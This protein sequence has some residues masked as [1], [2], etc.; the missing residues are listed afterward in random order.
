MIDRIECIFFGIVSSTSTP[1]DDGQTDEISNFSQDCRDGVSRR[2]KEDSGSKLKGC[3][4]PHR[5]ILIT[6]IGGNNAGI[7][8]T[9]IRVERV[10]SLVVY[11]SI[12]IKKP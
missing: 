1:A 8:L 12:L 9:N 7:G 10:S 11:I 4:R 3:C 5:V 2:Y 6:E